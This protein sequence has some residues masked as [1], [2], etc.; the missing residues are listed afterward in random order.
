M[1]MGFCCLW[2][3]WCIG[4]VEDD[5]IMLVYMLYMFLLHAYALYYVLSCIVH[6][7]LVI[8]CLFRCFCVYF[9]T[10]LSTK[11]LGIITF[12]CFE[13]SNNYVFSYFAPLYVFLPYMHIF[14]YDAHTHNLW[15]VEWLIPWLYHTFMFSIFTC[16]FFWITL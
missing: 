11:I 10:P 13:K 16:Q 14:S 15:H 5:G 9:W 6:T 12:P 2:W 1:N 4:F 8:K 7:M 3:N